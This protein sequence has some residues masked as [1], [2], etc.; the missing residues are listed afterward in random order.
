MTGEDKKAAAASASA[1]DAASATEIPRGDWAEWCTRASAEN[2]GR[3]VRV[4]FADDALG[5]VRLSDGMPLVTLDYDEL[6][7]A[8]AFSI[9]Y[10]DGV[11]PIRYV[12]AEPR[13]VTQELDAAGD[14]S[15]VI[16]EDSTNRRTVV[17]LS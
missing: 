14:L 1:G 5:E 4:T 3:A 9:R 2:K 13:R 17:G 7:S 11:V 6:G 15:R 16:I 12:I 10:G 8:V